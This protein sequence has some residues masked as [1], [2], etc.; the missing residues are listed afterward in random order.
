M[1]VVPL[2]QLT[3]YTQEAAQATNAYGKVIEGIRQANDA[4]MTNGKYQ[5]KFMKRFCDSTQ[6]NF[7]PFFEKAGMLRPIKALIEDYSREWLIITQD[8]IDELKSYVASKNYAEVPAALNYINA[9]NWE[10][11]RDKAAL[12]TDAT[13]GQGCSASG[14]RVKVDNNV[15]KNA[16]G[17]ETYDAD[18]NLLRISMFGLGDSQMSSR[19]TYVLFPSGAKYIMAVG[20]DGTKVKCYEK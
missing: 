15:W 11:F 19:Y 6:M 14:T 4:N 1:K 18:G 3:L 20:Y 9:Y 10:V 13:V 5:L 17:Y 16:V 12:T 2:W 7:L 8:Q